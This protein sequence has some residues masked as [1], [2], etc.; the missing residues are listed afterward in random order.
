[1][2]EKRTLGKIFK[3]AT[4]ETVGFI[5]ILFAERYDV[6]DNYFPSTSC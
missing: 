6:N 1:M 4:K 3:Q 5:Q 2:T